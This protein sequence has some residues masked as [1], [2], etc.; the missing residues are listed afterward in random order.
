VEIKC[1]G[2]RTIRVEK[3][4]NLIHLAIM[5]KGDRR[6]ATLQLEKEEALK[7]VGELNGLIRFNSEQK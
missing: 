3:F 5:W 1:I 2:R 7:L 4:D 6:I